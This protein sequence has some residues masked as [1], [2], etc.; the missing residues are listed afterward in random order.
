MEPDI[1]IEEKDPV[2][3]MTVPPDSPNKYSYKGKEY[4]FCRMGCLEKF[5]KDP[6]SY[7]LKKKPDR[8]SSKPGQEYTCPMDPEVKQ[9]GPGICPKCGMALEPATVSLDDEENPELRNMEFRFWISLFLSV[10]LVVL[11]MWPGQLVHSNWLHSIE[12]ILAT[13]VVLWGG[14]PFFVR[15]WNSLIHRSPNMFTLIGIGTGVSYVFSSIAF[16]RPGI[17]PK[18]FHDMHGAVPVYFEAAAAI[19][20]LV[21]LGQ[22]L[23]LRARSKTGAALKSLLGLAPKNAR[24]ILP[25]NSEIDV[26]LGSVIKGDRLRVRPGEKVPVDG[27]V[28]EGST[29]VDESMITGEPIPVEKYKGQTVIGATVNQNGTIIIEARHVG[30]EMALSH[31]IKAVAEA[32]RSRAP[33]QKLADKVSA[34]FVPAVVASSVLT[35]I[36]WAV[37]GPSLSYAIVNAVAVLIIACPCALGLATPMSIMVATGKG[38]QAGV[39]FKNAEAIEVLRKIDM[40]VVDKTGTL[41]EGKP[42]VALITTVGIVSEDDVLMLAASLELGS[43][44]P[45]AAAILDAAHEKSL[46]LKNVQHFESFP[47]RGITGSVDGHRFALGNAGLLEKFGIDDSEVIKEA[48]V[49]QADGQTVMFIIKDDRILGY[50]GV[51]DPI[52]ETSYDAVKSLLREGISLF[53]LTGD[54]KITADAA[55]RKLGIDRVKADVLPM[56]K[57][58]IIKELRRAEG[59]FVAMA[60]DGINDAPALAE[61]HVGIA[62]GNGTDIAMESAGVTLVKGDLRAIVKAHRL[63]LATMHNIRQNLFFAF[64]YNVIGIPIAAGAL[65]PFFGI[66]LSPMIA[67]AAMSLSSISVISNALRLR[68]VK[69]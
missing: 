8:A 41:T 25:D 31:I 36:L 37:F 50:I 39:L 62:M 4:L 66:L 59:R 15:A 19:T 35:F 27:K 23:E 12:F 44:H 52:K 46:T 10:P 55:A 34:Y 38:A 11:A 28:V 67:A 30:A 13:P 32:Q 45:L 18:T 61:A 6:E 68:N 24:R 14:A 33:V 49:V 48:S 26:P 43:E 3:G 53:M 9:I 42:K 51:T 65:Y 56:Q 57:A 54:N 69:L 17:F 64:F 47:G 2:C 58:Q 1:K 5:K 63:S 22:V 40:L 20:T 21:L 29:S 7:L 60:G 16:I